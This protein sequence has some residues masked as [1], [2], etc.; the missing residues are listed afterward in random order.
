M[1]HLRNHYHHHHHHHLAPLSLPPSL[2]L[3]A[4]CPPP[5]YLFPQVFAAN[6]GDDPWRGCTAFEDVNPTYPEDTAMCSGCGHCGDLHGSL[7][8]G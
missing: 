7:V 6:G 4:P 8:R 5:T 2:G 1:S 3:L